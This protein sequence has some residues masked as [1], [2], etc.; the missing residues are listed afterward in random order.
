[1]IENKASDVSY[2]LMDILITSSSTFPCLQVLVHVT[3]NISYEQ[4][5]LGQ[6]LIF[7]LY[8][9]PLL[10]EPAVIIL[11]HRIFR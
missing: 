7:P 9:S 5:K 2:G 3:L 11:F 1:M 6:L 10:K 8:V 4:D